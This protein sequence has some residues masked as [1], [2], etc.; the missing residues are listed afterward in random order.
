MLIVAI[1]P[2][3]TISA[4]IEWDG[5]KIYEYGIVTNP[6]LLQYLERAYKKDYPP[7]KLYIEALACMGGMVGRE[8]LETAFWSGRFVQQ[9]QL[10]GLGRGEYESIPRTTIKKHHKAKDDAGIRAVMIEKYGNPGT[11]KKPG[12]T[13]GLKSHLWQAFGLATYVTETQSDLSS[14]HR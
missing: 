2:G 4:Y 9:W 1:D 14:I 11:K 5:S 6:E 13:Y 10:Y 7:R 3:T 12:F 8:V